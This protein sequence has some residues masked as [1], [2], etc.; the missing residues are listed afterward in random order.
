[1]LKNSMVELVPVYRTTGVF[2]KDE[3]MIMYRRLAIKHW[4]VRADGATRR[5][6]FEKSLLDNIKKP[7]HIFSLVYIYTFSVKETLNTV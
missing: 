7:F 2:K 4:P 1:M 5:Q 3:N 6:I